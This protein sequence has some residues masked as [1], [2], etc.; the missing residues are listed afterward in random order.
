MTGS[1]AEDRAADAEFEDRVAPGEPVPEAAARHT[2]AWTWVFVAIVMASTVAPYLWHARAADAGEHFVGAVSGVHDSNVYFMWTE[3]ARAGRVLVH[4]LHTSEPHPPMLPN[5]P[6]FV[7]GWSA[8]LLSVEPVYTYHALRIAAG[9]AY[10]VLVW[11][12]AGELLRTSFEQKL[13]LAIAGAGAGLQ[14][15]ISAINSDLGSE[16]IPT[17][18]DHIPEV[19]G[20]HSV[21]TMPHFALSLAALALAVL[22][23]VRAEDRP[24][25]R[26][27]V[28]AFIGVAVLTH[29]HPYTSMVMLPTIGLHGLA[30]LLS[31]R[32]SGLSTSAWALAGAAPSIALLAYSYLTNPAAR[33]WAETVRLPSP[34]PVHYL[35]GL[36]LVAPLAIVGIV[37]ALRNRSLTAR[38]AL[39]LIWLA[40]GLV[41]I[42][43]A[44]INPLERRCV[45]GLHLP[46][47]L[48]AALGAGSLL[49][50]LQR[51]LRSR[52]AAVIAVAAVVA[53]QIVPTDLDLQRK[54]LR[55]PR[56]TMPARWLGLFEV[57]RAESGEWDALLCSYQ[58]GNY[59]P[60]FTLSPVYMG[61]VHMTQHL[62]A[63]KRALEL[64]QDAGTPL[65][66]RREILDASGCRWVILERGLSP[67]EAESLGLMLRTRS[68][69]LSLFE[70]RL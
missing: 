67:G 7:A 61:H 11:L 70:R 47:A 29:V 8:R 60:R 41:A 59:A 22:G 1:V 45:E 53:L 68:G 28:M 27:S 40:V 9:V 38:Y 23:L 6:W 49:P 62:D 15:H 36:G 3:Q 30:K 18:T 33:R 42:Y 39:L 4:N 13:A 56:A 26:W 58:M 12:I 2:T 50:G 52:R 54:M 44:P 43:S 16:V 69:G 5:L 19:W 24:D 25:R 10:L 20:Y 46:A 65:P 32:R 21:L 34:D 35:L 64:L 66:R 51:A 14:F 55:E 63:K 17:S 57:I 31:G 37:H 48:L